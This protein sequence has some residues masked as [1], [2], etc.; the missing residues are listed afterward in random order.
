MRFRCGL[1]RRG[2][3]GSTLHFL[4]LT[5]H[6]VAAIADCQFGCATAD[7]CRLDD[8]IR[9]LEL[10]KN[11]RALIEHLEPNDKRR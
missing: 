2:S 5:E 4:D 6:V 8:G 7:Q 9:I 1:G 10:V 3:N 11:A